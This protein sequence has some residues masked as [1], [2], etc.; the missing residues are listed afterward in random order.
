MYVRLIASSPARSLAH[1][2]IDGNAW[3]V[4][5]FGRALVYHRLGLRHIRWWWWPFLF[6]VIMFS[7]NRWV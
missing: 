7:F 3:L 1:G 2:H 5:V 4:V 6:T